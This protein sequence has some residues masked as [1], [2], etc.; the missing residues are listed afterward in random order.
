[1]ALLR[2][3]GLMIFLHIRTVIGQ[4]AAALRAQV[5]D[6]LKKKFN[7]EN[8][9]P[10]ST[11]NLERFNQERTTWLNR[12]YGNSSQPL[13]SDEH[14][15]MADVHAYFQIASAVSHDNIFFIDLG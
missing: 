13:Y 7:M 5:S 6:L 12:I 1:M 14:K 2:L 9:S 15:V 8:S 11:A 3:V 10:L 4:E